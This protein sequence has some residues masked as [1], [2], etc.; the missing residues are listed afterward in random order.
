MCKDDLSLVRGKPEFSLIYQ[1]HKDE[2]LKFKETEIARLKES[3]EEMIE[4]SLIRELPSKHGFFQ[5]SF[6]VIN[7]ILFL[8][9]NLSQITERFLFCK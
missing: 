8:T 3:N 5:Q 4:Q 6:K 9:K 7:S 1:T 2:E